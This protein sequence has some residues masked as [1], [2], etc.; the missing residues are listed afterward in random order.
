MS[1]NTVVSENNE[2]YRI[3]IPLRIVHAMRLKKGDVLNW[4]ICSSKSVTVTRM[5]K[6]TA[7]HKDTLT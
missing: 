5:I 1:E 3:T 2:Q 4:T 6:T 7:I